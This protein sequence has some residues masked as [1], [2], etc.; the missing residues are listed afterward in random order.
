MGH[1]QK[2][3]I[4]IY[5]RNLDKGDKL[6]LSIKTGSVNAATETNEIKSQAINNLKSA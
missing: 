1:F 3:T 5:Q 4:A 2:R 6:E